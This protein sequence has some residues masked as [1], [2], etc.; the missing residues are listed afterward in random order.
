MYT[1]LID[2]GRIFNLKS[3]NEI[4]AFATLFSFQP[5]FT[6]LDNNGDEINY[7]E[8]SLEKGDTFIAYDN[9]KLRS[10]IKELDGSVVLYRN[11]P[12][13]TPIYIESQGVLKQLLRAGNI[14]DL[15]DD[16]ILLESFSRKLE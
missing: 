9:R 3:N 14:L 15:E 13:Y 12:E 7:D 5:I 1:L 8:W 6:I 2:D 4:T 10:K 16:L 11:P